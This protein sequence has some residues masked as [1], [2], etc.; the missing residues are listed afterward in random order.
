M[1]DY[2]TVFQEALLMRLMPVFQEMT[3]PAI[4]RFHPDQYPSLAVLAGMA[5]LLGSVVLYGFG[6]WIRRWP[7]RISTEAQQARIESMR[8]IARQWLPYLLVLSPTPLGGILIVAAGFFRLTPIVAGL[9]IV[10]AEVLWRIS[11]ML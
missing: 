6:V 10:A 4:Q 5:A 3:L 9:A 1:N 8:S 2:L 7:E 11:P